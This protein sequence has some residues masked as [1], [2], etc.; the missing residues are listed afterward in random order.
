[1]AIQWNNYLSITVAG[2]KWFTPKIIVVRYNYNWKKLLVETFLFAPGFCLI[3]AVWT[4]H[5]HTAAA[6]RRASSSS[7]PPSVNTWCFWPVLFYVLSTTESWEASEWE[8]TAIVVGHQRAERDRW[9]RCSSATPTR[10]SAPVLKWL[11]AFSWSQTA[12][13]LWEPEVRSVLLLHAGQTQGN[14]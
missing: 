12:T 9:S 4:L 6:S 3:S 10:P 14:T 7:P 5:F 13:I 1:M 8:F 11:L 2:Q